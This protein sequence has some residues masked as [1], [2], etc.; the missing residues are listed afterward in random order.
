MSEL[1]EAFKR[2]G[3]GIPY[4]SDEVSKYISGL[5]KIRTLGGAKTNLYVE[6]PVKIFENLDID[7]TSH[8]SIGL[9]SYVMSA[10][11]RVRTEIGRYCSIARD[12]VIGEPNHPIN[13]LSTSPFQYNWKEKWGWHD[14]LK[15]HQCIEIKNEDKWKIFGKRVVV[16][17][18]VWVGQGVQ[19]LR[20]VT[21]GTGSIVAAGAVVAKDVLPYSIVGGIPARHIKFR[22][23]DETRRRL[24]KSKWWLM[25]PKLL[26]GVDFTNVQKALDQV[27]E[28]K[29]KTILCDRNFHRI[30]F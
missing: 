5:D 6:A 13:W 23:D 24:I 7:S 10:R 4:T 9:C 15:D 22:F 30:L 28:I 2:S 19:I 16:S 17:D 18:D 3:E 1:E 20:G 12:V 25:D 21:L 27:D 29:N 14:M 11:I 8:V 26:S